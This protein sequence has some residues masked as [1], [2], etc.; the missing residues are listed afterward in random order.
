MG[1]TDKVD[2]RHLMTLRAAKLQSITPDTDNPP[3]LRHCH[4]YIN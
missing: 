4:G 1:V 2:I 3:T